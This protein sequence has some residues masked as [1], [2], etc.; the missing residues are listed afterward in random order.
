MIEADSRKHCH[1]GAAMVRP[2]WTSVDHAIQLP[3]LLLLTI[4]YMHVYKR[5]DDKHVLRHC[6]LMSEH[7]TPSSL[8]GRQ[9]T[10][11]FSPRCPRHGSAAAPTHTAPAAILVSSTDPDSAAAAAAASAVHA[12]FL[13]PTLG[14]GSPCKQQVLDAHAHAASRLGAGHI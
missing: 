5:P 8:Q 9:R 3:I 4:W 12:I 11:C 13:P 1:A 2:Q 14:A 6:G 7:G 10:P